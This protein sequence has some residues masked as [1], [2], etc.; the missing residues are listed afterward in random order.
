MMEQAWL[1]PL[2]PL[3]ASILLLMF[4][5]KL[6]EASAHI[7]I[8]GVF[9]SF[10]V[11]ILV[12]VDRFTSSTFSVEWEW[13]TLGEIIVTAGIEITAINSLMLFVVS[14][15]S[16]IVHIY[17]KGYMHGEERFSTFYAY[18]SFFTFAMLALVMSPN[19]LQVYF[20]WEL[21]GLG[22]FLLIGFYYFKREAKQAAKKAFIMTRIGDVG[23]LAGIIILYI[24]VGSFRIQ[25]IY[26]AVDQGLIESGFATLAALLIFIGAVGKSGQF[27]LHTWLP[28][29]ME[30]PTPV[31]A[32]IHAAT[33]VAAGVYLV[34][35]LYPL[36]S[37]SQEAMFMVA[38]IG[39]FTAIFAATIAL[40]QTDIKRIL[41]YSTVSQLGYMML[42]L[43]SAGYVAAV[44]HLTTHAFF[45]ALLFLAAGSV[46]HAVG[47]QDIREMGG[48]SKK[49][50][51]TA[52]LFL[53]GTLAISGVPL[54]SGFFSKDEILMSAWSG[55]TMILFILALITTF[56]TAFYMFRL[57]FSVFSGEANGKQ[58]K[59]HE[60][61]NIM[62]APMAVLAF[63]AIFIGYIQTPWFGH[64]LGD[65]LTEGTTLLGHSHVEGPVWV[66]LAS[67]LLS[68]SGIGLAYLMYSKGSIPKDVV[69]GGAPITTN[70]LRNK[71]YVDELYNGTIVRGVGMISLFLRFIDRYL[72]SGIVRG[73]TG[74]VVY[75]GKEGS[76]FQT[77]QVQWYGTVAVVG[78]AL[79]LVIYMLSGGV[80]K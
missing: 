49:L 7:G 51:K 22:S 43:G 29:A 80:L 62:V 72:V 45:K 9:L 77:G 3:V 67:I 20:F 18:L 71:Y 75:L 63:F 37:L 60:S 68:L 14:I 32:L 76:R 42:A 30:G 4:G 11:S 10:L 24:H 47:T 31:S 39:G 56:L 61:P 44:F 19:L 35:V 21:V 66:M 17:S 78:L 2:L 70:I 16:L 13:F 33:M 36:F 73:V 52:P 65:W 6:G 15:V 55:E 48:L 59:V 27:P 28:D 38:L 12:L 74:F 8:L 40:T 5:K 58:K 53:I 57:Y 54:L 50:K 79:F 26:Q 41:A 23:F 25:D 64:F 1:I 46:I 34:A 69:S